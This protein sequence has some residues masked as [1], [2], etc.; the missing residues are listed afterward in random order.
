MSEFMDYVKVQDLREGDMVDL[1]G[2]PYADAETDCEDCQTIHDMFAYE[3]S[4]VFS[5][6]Q[7]TP[8]CVAVGFD[9]DVVGFP[10][11]HTLFVVSRK[12]REN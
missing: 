4:I 7:E 12:E 10:T 11:N 5:V 3:F 8:E 9:H 1:E 2:D 6:E